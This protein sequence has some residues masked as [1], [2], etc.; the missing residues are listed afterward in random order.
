M[1]YR[2]RN[3]HTVEKLVY[4]CWEPLL[5]AP[6]LKIR[7]HSPTGFSWGYLGSGPSQL[8]LALLLDAMDAQTVDEIADITS[9]YQ[10]FKT[11]FVAKWHTDGEWEIDA[12][13]IHDWLFERGNPL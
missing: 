10:N 3:G 12:M 9:E 2:G 1:K 4:G 7:N 5:L 13:T 8:A 11:K 6:S